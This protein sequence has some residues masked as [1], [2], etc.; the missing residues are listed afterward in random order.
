[1]LSCRGGVRWWC[2][3]GAARGGWRGHGQRRCSG[4]AG[5]RSRLE[6]LDPVVHDVGELRRAAGCGVYAV[7]R[8]GGGSGVPGVDGGRGRGEVVGSVEGGGA[9]LCRGKVRRSLLGG[10]VSE[11][12][13]GSP[14]AP[15]GSALR[16]GLGWGVH[17]AGADAWR[18]ARARWAALS[19]M[20]RTP[21][22]CWITARRA[23]R[24]ARYP[25]PAFRLR[26]GGPR[27]LAWRRRR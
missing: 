11:P 24:R 20:R 26:W 19:R 14:D 22:G 27:R 5:R 18:V 7:V 3:S 16:G 12:S 15:P 8:P 13:L 1:M 25:S 17:R 4:C 2:R 10:W 21:G 9:S 6:T 23:R